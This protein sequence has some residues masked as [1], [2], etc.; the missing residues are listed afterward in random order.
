M[1]PTT[2]MNPPPTGYIPTSDAM[3][4][5]EYGVSKNRKAAST[6]GGRAWSEDEVRES[7]DGAV[8]LSLQPC[9]EKVLRRGLETD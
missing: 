9:I 4:R 8:T 1:S 5:H 2:Q 7:K 6:G 3:D